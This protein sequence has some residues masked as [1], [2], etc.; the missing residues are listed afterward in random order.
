MS[1]AGRNCENRIGNFF[2]DAMREYANTDFA[3][4][5]TGQLRSE[6][7]FPEEDFVAYIEVQR[8]GQWREASVI[9]ETGDR[10][11]VCYS[12]DGTFKDVAKRD[13]REKGY[14]LTMA[15]VSNISPWNDTTAVLEV[16]SDTIYDILDLSISQWPKPV[17]AFLQVSGLAFAFEPKAKDGKY[18]EGGKVADVWTL[19]PDNQR[20][21]TLERGDT[22]TM[23]KVAMNSF[24]ANRGGSKIV[25][26]GAAEAIRDLKAL[27]VGSSPIAQVFEAGAVKGPWSFVVTDP[28]GDLL[29]D[30]PDQKVVQPRCRIPV[31]SG[32]DGYEKILKGKEAL[33]GIE[34]LKMRDIVCE[35]LCNKS[36]GFQD[37]I[38]PPLGRIFMRTS[39]GAPVLCDP[40]RTPAS[41][42]ADAKHR[43]DVATVRRIR[44]APRPR[45]NS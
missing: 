28:N 37:W 3:F 6:R 11:K 18:V 32:H 31:G 43:K 5:G 23:W 30:C 12:D 7:A 35:K 1:K 34:L 16:S 39:G 14:K 29:P 19:G 4:I 26:G 36:E 40:E 9:G 45:P 20:G 42:S 13:V 22:K 15:D 2:T 27:Q 8:D 41:G 44:S 24:L 33:I 10:Y 25:K 17:G 38:I 21:T